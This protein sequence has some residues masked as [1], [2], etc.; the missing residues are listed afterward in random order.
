M[1]CN[2]GAD[3]KK[4]VTAGYDCIILPGAMDTAN[5]VKPP[6]L[7]G[8]QMGI[9]TAAGTTQKTVCCKSNLMCNIYQ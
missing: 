9:I 4:I 5:A 6:K 1:C 7:C 2:Y 3:G 8:S